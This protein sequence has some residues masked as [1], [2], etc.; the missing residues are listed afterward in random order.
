MK[1]RGN[2]SHPTACK[3]TRKIISTGRVT[4]RRVIMTSFGEGCRELLGC[5]IGSA[6]ACRAVD[7][8]D[9]KIEP[10]LPGRPAE[11]I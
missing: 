8:R 11:I 2:F 1:R 3:M 7:S 5:E 10:T 6:A 4:S 9:T